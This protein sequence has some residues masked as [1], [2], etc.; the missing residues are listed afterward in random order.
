MNICEYHLI[1]VLYIATTCCHEN[2]Q[3]SY[4]TPVSRQSSTSS[5]SNGSSS[6]AC[7]SPKSTTS[8]CTSD[9]RTPSISSSDSNVEAEINQ[10]I[11]ESNSPQDK[12]SKKLIAHGD[13]LVERDGL[14]DDIEDED[15]FIL[16]NKF[17]PLKPPKD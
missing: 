4:S 5:S 7:A 1:I 3:S 2:N 14:T 9:K 10:S 17:P 13:Y 16:V 11:E 12:E 15:G 6:T 8:S